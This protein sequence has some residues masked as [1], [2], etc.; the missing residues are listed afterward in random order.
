M[1]LPRISRKP[2]LLALVAGSIVLFGQCHKA[3]EF[4]VDEFDERLSGGAATVFDESSRAFTHSIPSLSARD[5]YIHGLGD[6]AFEQSFVAAPAPLHGGL[7]PIFNN[8]SC[9]SCHHNDGKGI[10]TA[11]FANSS[12]LFR[13]SEPGTDPF[14]GPLGVPGYGGQLQDQ[15]VQGSF[16]EGKVSI[17]YTEKTITYPDG[18]TA[19]LRQPTYTL[20]QHYAPLPGGY[21]LSPRLAPPVFGLGLLELIPEQT[22]LN[23]SD[24]NDADG[25]GISGRPNYVF[26]NEHNRR[27]IGRFGLKAN[28]PSILTQVAGAL[29]QDMGIT[30]KIFPVESSFGQPQAPAATEG[31]E[32]A[33]TMLQAIAFYIKTLA[34]PARRN[35]RDAAVLQGQK[36]F[37]QIGCDRCHQPTLQTG[38]DVRYPWISN[39]R[40]HP[41]TDLLL[42][43]MG[44]GLAD[45]RPDFEATGREWRTPPLW[46]IGLFEKV[47][48]TPYFLHDGRARSLEEAILWHGG[49]AE[50]AKSQFM[51][52]N[53]ADRQAVIRFLKSL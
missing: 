4:P 3:N 7:G 27:A 46:G 21:A 18:T 24:P 32:L 38:V 53:L 40:I 35:T 11:G 2:L 48:G 12:L 20:A 44:E 14:G 49:E 36:L 34:V 16:P 42:H 8:V 30:S 13:I 22:L 26:D 6:A 19:S 5:L 41:Y 39:Q 1:K 52:L 15:A 45:N 50:H 51:Q 25:D 33:D 23:L 31:Y 17:S 28:M 47:N 9:I 43:D 10:P 37:A 29:N